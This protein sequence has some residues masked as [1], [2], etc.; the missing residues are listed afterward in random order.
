MNSDGNCYGLTGGVKWDCFNIPVD[1][2]GFSIL[3]GMSKGD[4]YN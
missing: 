2:N 3:T 4:R 1:E